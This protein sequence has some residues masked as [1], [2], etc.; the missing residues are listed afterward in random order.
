MVD[1]AAKEPDRVREMTARWQELEAR[2]R[3]QAGPP[4]KEKGKA[5]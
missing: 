1:L 5:K 4:P 2:F 3:A